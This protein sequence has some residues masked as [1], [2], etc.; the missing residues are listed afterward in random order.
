VND[1]SAITLKLHPIDVALSALSE[2]AA[3][4]LAGDRPSRF[5]EIQRITSVALQVQRLR[6][7]SD[8]HG[9]LEALDN[10][11]QIYGNNMNFVHGAVMPARPFNDVADINRELIMAAQSFFDQQQG[12]K[13]VSE[14]SELMALRSRIRKGGEGEVP[15]AIQARIDHL[16]KKMGESSRDNEPRNDSVV[17]AEPVRRH[18]LDEQGAG[19]ASRMG[20]PLAQ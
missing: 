16:L 7:P 2:I 5:A 1:P 20:E 10:V 3:D 17:P 6:T 14:L 11:P 8:V 4:L 13:T 18:P 19:D 9:A 12:G 15:E